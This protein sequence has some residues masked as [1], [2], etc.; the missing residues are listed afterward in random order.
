MRGG[1]EAAQVL[2]PGV[3]ELARREKQGWQVAAPWE[4]R[5]RHQRV[6]KWGQGCREGLAA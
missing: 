4:E 3:A 6:G 1:G 2:N 5:N